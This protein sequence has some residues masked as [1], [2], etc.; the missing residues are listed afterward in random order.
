MISIHQRSD[1]HPRQIDA[2]DA[3]IDKLV[4][5]PYDLAPDEIKIVEGATA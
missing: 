2:T 5:E 3:R 4:Y 1:S